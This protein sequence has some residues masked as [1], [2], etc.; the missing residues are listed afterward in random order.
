MLKKYGIYFAEEE[1]SQDNDD[2]D[3]DDEDD[4]DGDVKEIED[5]QHHED[6]SDQ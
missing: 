2:E 4:V 6:R 1:D 3:D 5:G